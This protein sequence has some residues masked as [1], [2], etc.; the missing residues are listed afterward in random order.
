MQNPNIQYVFCPGTIGFNSPP[1]VM[2]YPMIPAPASP[3]P[4]AS[5]WPILTIAFSKTAVS[6]C[7]LYSYS[8]FVWVSV[9]SDFAK[10]ITPA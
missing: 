9:V 5:K 7:A 10:D 3:K 8:S 4:S 2:F 1:L 6:Y